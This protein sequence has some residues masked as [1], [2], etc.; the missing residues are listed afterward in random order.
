MTAWYVTCLFGLMY[1]VSYVDRLVLTLLIEPLK[2]QF[3][4][5]DTAVSLLIGLSF[6]LFYALVGLP[7]AR[8]ADRG[9]RRNLVVAGVL[10]WSGCTI[11]SA[12]AGSFA[13]LAMLRVGVAVGE[14]VLT[15]CAVS[16]ISDLFPAARRA[17]ATS[18]YV[19]CGTLGAFG[20]Y[21]FGGLAVAAAGSSAAIALPLLGEMAP[22][23]VVF[24]LVGLPGLILG[25][26]CLATVRE[27]PRSGR[28]QAAASSTAELR[29]YLRLDGPMLSRLF[30]GSSLGQLLLLGLSTWTPSFLVRRFGWEVADAGIALGCFGIA[31]SAIGLTLIPKLANRWTLGGRTDALPIVAAATVGLPC[32]IIVA[33]SFMTSGWAFLMTASIAF[34]PLVCSGTLAMIAI[35]WVGPPRLQAMLTAILFLVNSLLAFALGPFLVSVI[36][37]YRWFG[38]ADLGAAFAWTAVIAGPL[39]TVL[40]WQSRASF[41][42]AYERAQRAG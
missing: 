11:A 12:W 33:A 37:E 16:M 23:R 36:A 31:A 4:V 20:A 32:V 17:T 6:A 18:V 2:A 27:P 13:V 42:R 21:V 28:A 24:L 10:L 19:F 7:L 26:A 39:G 38:A 1:I 15:P 41:S 30:A 3:M 8:L 22:W 40:L 35:Q 25:L 29:A 34:V 14:A 5:G 9:N